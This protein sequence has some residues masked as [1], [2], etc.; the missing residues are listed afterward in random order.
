MRHHAAINNSLRAVS[1][2]R[3]Q[4]FSQETGL[5]QAVAVAQLPREARRHRS[6]GVDGE[7]AHLDGGRVPAVAAVPATFVHGRN[8]FGTRAE[9]NQSTKPCWVLRPHFGIGCRHE[10]QPVEGAVSG[11]LDCGA[12]LQTILLGVFGAL[13]LLPACIGIY[14]VISHSVARHVWEMGSGWRWARPF[15][16]QLFW[17][18]G[19]CGLPIPHAPRHRGRPRDSAAR[20][21]ARISRLAYLAEAAQLSDRALV[22]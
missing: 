21:V 14:A 17:C 1:L 12:R 9:L 22:Q 10:K 15:W 5:A 13:G 11:W 8:S 3:C 6:V 4:S 2:D 19:R 16:P 7:R 20:G 18:R